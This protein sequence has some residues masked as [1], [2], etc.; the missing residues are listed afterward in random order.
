MGLVVHGFGGFP[1]AVRPMGVVLSVPDFIGPVTLLLV[2]VVLISAQTVVV[3]LDVDVLS[4]RDFTGPVKVAPLVVVLD[5]DVAIKVAPVLVVLSVDVAKAV[6]MV[7]RVSNSALLA[8]MVVVL[9]VDAAKT[10][11]VVLSVPD[12]AIIVP[13]VVV[14]SVNAAV[15]VVLSVPNSAILV[16]MV[17]V[18]NVHVAKTVVVILS[19]FDLFV[20]P[21]PVTAITAGAGLIVIF[22]TL[23]TIWVPELVVPHA[24]RQVLR[25][26]LVRNF[27]CAPGPAPFLW[28]PPAPPKSTE[29]RVNDDADKLLRVGARL[30]AAGHGRSRSRSLQCHMP[31]V[32]TTSGAS[33]GQ[34]A[35]KL[36]ASLED[37][38]RS[39]MVVVAGGRRGVQAQKRTS[40][41]QPTRRQHVSR[42]LAT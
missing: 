5:V 12:S 42:W 31:M 38:P 13:M 9:S 24:D 35:G 20:F 37:N 11:V 1:K 34:R 25:R 41:T 39:V 6:V 30:G 10:M 27:A 16:S 28:L 3:V 15:M 4:V 40:G 22:F 21:V 14:L 23:F 17:V 32:R 18:R 19:A 33:P 8:P 26:V 7:L 36:R 29:H 2:V